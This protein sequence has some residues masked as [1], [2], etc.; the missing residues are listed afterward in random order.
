MYYSIDFI[1]SEGCNQQVLLL[2]FSWDT[3]LRSSCTLYT[4]QYLLSVV[5]WSHN[6]IPDILWGK[7]VRNIRSHYTHLY[8]LLFPAYPPSLTLRRME[9]GDLYRNCIQLHSSIYIPYNNILE[10]IFIIF[11][12]IIKSIMTPSATFSPHKGGS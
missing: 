6:Q 11:F 2:L 12:F 5:S 8:Q 1:S 3:A 7:R 10:P 9:S 4:R